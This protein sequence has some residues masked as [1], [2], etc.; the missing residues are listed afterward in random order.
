M[1]L[2]RNIFFVFSIFLLGCSTNTT[3][4]SVYSSL[5]ESS[6]LPLYKEPIKLAEQ[7][8]STLEEYRGNILSPDDLDN[9]DLAD[10]SDG[11]VINY[12]SSDSES[13]KYEYTHHDDSYHY[14]NI[15]IEGYE[16]PAKYKTNGKYSETAR[17]GSTKFY[18]DPNENCK[19]V[20]GNC[21]YDGGGGRVININTSYVNG[22]WIIKRK[23]YGLFG[24]LFIKYIYDKNGMIIYTSSFNNRD[25]NE[26]SYMIR[27][28]LNQN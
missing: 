4:R 6:L 18:A 9:I 16:E 22:V 10:I 2:M 19:F 11:L 7:I 8:E 28:N 3:N 17:I 14:F 21:S 12:L 20:L 13:V 23:S 5:E 25:N 26:Y 27:S 24:T 1:T 15:F